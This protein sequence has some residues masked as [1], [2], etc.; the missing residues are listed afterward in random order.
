M[1]NQYGLDSE[2]H[3]EMIQLN[4]PIMGDVNQ[5]QELNVIDV[6]YILGYILDTNVLDEN[7]VALADINIDGLISVQ[8]IILIVNIILNS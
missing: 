1:R 5:D 2:P 4:P 6:L 7:Q 3:I 8:D